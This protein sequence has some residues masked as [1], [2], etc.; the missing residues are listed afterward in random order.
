MW[1]GLFFN[2]RQGLRAACE[3]SCMGPLTD[4][5]RAAAGQAS[6]YMKAEL[7]ESIEYFKDD[8]PKVV[9]S[10]PDDGRSN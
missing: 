3:A 1:L 9:G 2:A 5:A 6:N 10:A 7:S 4:L 8:D